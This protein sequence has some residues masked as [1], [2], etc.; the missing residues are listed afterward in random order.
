MLAVSNSGERNVTV[1]PSAH[2]QLTGGQHGQ[3]TFPSEYY[4]GGNTCF[5]TFFLY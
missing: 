4:E 2:I 5:V 3:R 1:C